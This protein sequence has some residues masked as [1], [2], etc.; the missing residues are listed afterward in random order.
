VNWQESSYTTC[1]GWDDCEK[2]VN[3]R[4]VP[5]WVLSLSPDTKVACGHNARIFGS[6]TEIQPPVPELGRLNAVY[7]LEIGPALWSTF[8]YDCTLDQAK[9]KVEEK[10]T[11][12]IDQL[13]AIVVQWEEHKLGKMLKIA[14]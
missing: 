7:Q 13:K 2:P 6:V 8:V 11:L 9:A 12:Y 4:Q 10:L 1:D 5:C 14:S 3:E